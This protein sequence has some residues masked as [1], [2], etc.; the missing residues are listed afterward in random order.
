MQPCTAEPLPKSDAHLAQSPYYKM[1]S[2][3][4]VL[5]TLLQLILGREEF[6]CC[7]VELACIFHF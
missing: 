1:F 7:G 4:I 6:S 5:H 3:I 2:A